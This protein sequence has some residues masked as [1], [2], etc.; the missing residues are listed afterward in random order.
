MTKSFTQVLTKRS[1]ITY[2]LIFCFTFSWS[3]TTKHPQYF[4]YEKKVPKTF[5]ANR[6]A[7]LDSVFQEL[8]DN[9]TIPHAVTFVAHHGKV[10]HN[11]AFGLRN[12]ENK[13][14]CRTDDLFRMASQTKAITAVAVLQLMEQGKIQLD[15]P[16]KK[17]IP[18]FA[19]PKVLS[20]VNP[21]DSSFTSVPANKDITIRH[22][23]THTSGISYGWSSIR[24]VYDKMGIPISPLYSL[25][26]V[27]LGDIIK[28][29]ATCPLEHNP[30][31]KFSYGMSVDVL[32][33]LIEVVSG[34][35]VDQYFKLNIFEPLGM[36][37]T[38]FYLPENIENRMVTLYDKQLNQAL[39]PNIQAN[40]IF[41][42]F[43]YAGA[44]TLFSTGAGLSGPIED[45]A[46]FCQMI[47]ND[48]EFNGKRI[49]GRKTIELM[50]KN[51]VGDLRGEIGFGLAF[52]DFRKE[53]SFRSIASEGS[54]RWGGMFGTDYIIDPQEDLILLFYI[55]LQPNASGIDFKVLFH[56][57]VYQ[58]MK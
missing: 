23:L 27:S 37:N 38:Y 39:K 22:L 53:Y 55:N 42:T 50:R 18:E 16:I 30:G 6:L 15:D 7:R 46:K 9:G 4:S 26:A 14:P 32:G 56:N 31:E 34:M 57:L 19:N 25:Q 13:I 12:I 35:P 11:K 20:I 52:D 33:Y 48:G 17:Y 21:K 51:E 43:P 2:L 40:G 1:L 10:V 3:Q 44:K 54:L 41:Q 29:L 45:Y 5:D 24:L 47:L 49:L 36:R 8:V 58:A 28:K